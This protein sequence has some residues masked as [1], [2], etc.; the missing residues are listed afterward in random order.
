M[1][2]EKHLK[3]PFGNYVLTNNDPKSTNTNAPILLD[4]I[5]LQATDSG[6]GGHNIQHLQTDSAITR[7]RVAPAPITP[8][9]I[10]QVHSIA[11]REG[12][13]SGMK[14]ANII[15]LVLYDSAWI[16]GVDYSEDDDYEDEFENESGN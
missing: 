1:D 14:I 13:P 7:N 12:M 10:N 5:Y 9:T 16:A 4:L 6:Q 8:K 15:R 2:Y 11:D 3:T